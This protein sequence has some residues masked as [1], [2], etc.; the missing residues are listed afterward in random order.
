MPSRTSTKAHWQR[1]WSGRTAIDDV[2][3]NDGRIVDELA[4]VRPLT[5]LRVLEVGAGSGRDAVDCAA[6]G[7][8]LVVTLDYTRE[9]LEI[10]QRL[11]AAEAA[12][13]VPI[14]ADATRMPFRTGVFDVVFHQGLMEH[15]RD[16]GPLLTE[17]RRVLAPGGLVLVDV[18]QRYHLYTLIKKVLIAC[19]RWFA[20]WETEYSIGELETLVC[21]HGFQLRRSYGAWMVPGLAYRALR[22][23]LLVAGIRLPKYPRWGAGWTSGLRRRCRSLRAAF[24]TYLDIG[25]I[26]EKE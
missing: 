2:Y 9:S 15:F 5:A 8:A 1:F 22:R 16:P 20:G 24:Y 19:N 13:V 17:N 3:S 14:C 25:V 11:A 10:I 12:R 7:A 26:G 23:G 18:P 4:G 21:R 6:R